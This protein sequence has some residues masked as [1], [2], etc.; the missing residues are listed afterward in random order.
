MAHSIAPAG[1]YFPG[2]QGVQVDLSSEGTE[3]ASHVVQLA[4]PNGATWFAA[5]ASHLLLIIALPGSH[6]TQLER[7]S[8]GAEP[9]SHVSHSAEPNGAT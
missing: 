9:A 8:E 1:L 2:E 6:L 4:E 5:H 3:P 7:S